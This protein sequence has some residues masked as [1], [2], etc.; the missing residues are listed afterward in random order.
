MYSESKCSNWRE[1]DPYSSEIKLR[2]PESRTVFRAAGAE[3]VVAERPLHPAFLRPYSAKDVTRVL[4]EIPPQFLQGL[5]RVL[6][7]G[8]TRKQEATALGRLFYW[9]SYVRPGTVHLF[10]YP[11]RA[12]RLRYRKPPSKERMIEWEFAQPSVSRDGG[13]WIVE[14]TAAG[15]RE[16]YLYDVLPHEIGHHVDRFREHKKSYRES[17]YYA[18]WFADRFGRPLRRAA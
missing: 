1:F 13:H 10:A 6:L 16:F 12:M 15:L 11:R 14:F 2:R 18:E 5:G 3:V 17:E 8:G 4:A 9:G 7:L